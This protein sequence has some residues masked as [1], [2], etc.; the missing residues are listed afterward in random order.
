MDTNLE[1]RIYNN[2]RAALSQRQGGHAASRRQEARKITVGRYNV[3][4]AQ[5]KDIV[6]R[7]DEAAGVTH[8]HTAD[9]LLALKVKAAQEAYDSSP[10]PC[11]MCGSEEMVRVRIHPDDYSRRSDNDAV[12]FTVICFMCH[13]RL[14]KKV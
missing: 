13:L 6:K 14:E 5:V 4:Y 8:E 11:S 7:Y 9:Y 3:S 1:T 12:R 10:T 2:Y